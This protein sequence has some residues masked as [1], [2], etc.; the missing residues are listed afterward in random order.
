MSEEPLGTVRSVGRL[1]PTGVLVVRSEPIDHARVYSVT[2]SLDILQVT[3]QRNLR[4][5]DVNEVLRIVARFL[6]DSSG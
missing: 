4:S 3:A 1:R 5:S 2:V 6:N